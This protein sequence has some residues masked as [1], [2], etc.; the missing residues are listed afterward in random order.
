[1]KSTNTPSAQEIT[2]DRRGCGERQFT[3][4]IDDF[5]VVHVAD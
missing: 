4:V 3:H 2:G 5:R 1:M